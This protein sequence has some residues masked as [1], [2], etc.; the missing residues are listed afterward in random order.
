M[1][2]MEP[3]KEKK[4]N[5][6]KD[7]KKQ[8]TMEELPEDEVAPLPRRVVM[9]LDA[10]PEKMIHLKE[11]EERKQQQKDEEERRAIE[12][13]EKK[14]K[15]DGTASQ[16]HNKSTMGE[17]RSQV[18]GSQAEEQ[19]LKRKESTDVKHLENEEIQFKYIQDKKVLTIEP[20]QKGVQEIQEMCHQSEH[21]PH[22]SFWVFFDSIKYDHPSRY[23]LNQKTI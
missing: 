23:K 16:T 5:E 22:I 13:E 21:G 3:L 10:Y 1:S 8:E 9:L 2:S 12:E 17:N 7:L 20:E 4:Q 11:E 14:K 15:K 18:Q 19:K 6:T